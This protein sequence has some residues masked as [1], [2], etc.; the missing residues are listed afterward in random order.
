MPPRGKMTNSH[1]AV[2]DNSTSRIIKTDRYSV[3][4]NKEHAQTTVP[5]LVPTRMTTTQRLTLLEWEAVTNRFIV[6]DVNSSP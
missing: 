4:G 5:M 2:M 1:F 6:G 3:K